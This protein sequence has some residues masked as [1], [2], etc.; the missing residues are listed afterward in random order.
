MSFDAAV[1]SLVVNRTSR[2]Q[3]VRMTTLI[4]VWVVFTDEGAVVTVNSEK[5]LKTVS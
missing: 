4:T 5:T 1:C 3:T 2:W